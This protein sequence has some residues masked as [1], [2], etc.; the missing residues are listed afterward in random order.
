MHDSGYNISFIK[1]K[2]YI[3]HLGNLRYKKVR[4]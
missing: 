2:K 4:D 3:Y 1:K